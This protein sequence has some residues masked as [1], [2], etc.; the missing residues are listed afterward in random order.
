M[1]C[2]VY[3]RST[4]GFNARLQTQTGHISNANRILMHQEMRDICNKVANNTDMLPD[5]YNLTKPTCDSVLR[6]IMY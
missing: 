3:N 2:S 5:N 4:N 6:L 1:I